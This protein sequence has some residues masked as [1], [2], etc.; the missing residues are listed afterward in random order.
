M[1]CDMKR[2]YHWIGMKKDVAVWVSKCPT[3][4]LVKAEHQVPSGLMQSLPMPEWKWDIVTM[5]FVTGLPMGRSKHNAVWVIVDRLTKSAHFVAISETD[6]AEE[7]V[8][9]YLEEIVRLH[10]VPAASCLTVT[11]SSPHISRRLFKRPYGQG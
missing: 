5:D 3:C 4:Q 8:A 6:G 2:Y 1:Y 11:H 10:G 9:K 7:I